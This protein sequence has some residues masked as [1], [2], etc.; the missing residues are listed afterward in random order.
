MIPGDLQ[1]PDCREEY[2]AE[3]FRD[4][5]LVGM[6]CPAC[7]K[8]VQGA[9]EDLARFRMSEPYPH[10]PSRLELRRMALWG[11]YGA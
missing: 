1:C 3:C 10:A 8:R 4:H 5:V 11:E 6:L 9:C 2:P 7:W